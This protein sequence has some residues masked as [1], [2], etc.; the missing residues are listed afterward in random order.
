MKRRILRLTL[1]TCFILAVTAL[2]TVS[3][4]AE[5][6]R[7]GDLTY[8]VSN[9]EITIT[10]CESSVTS[11]TIPSKIN[12][13]PVASIGYKA[14]SWCTSLTSISIPDSV[15]SIGS[16]AFSWCT[17]LT[18][19]S[20]PDSVTSIGNYAFSGCTRLTSISIPDSVTSIGV[21]AFWYCTSLTSISIPDSV[22]SIGDSAFQEC[23][24]LTSVN[25]P[26]SVTSIGEGAFY[27]CSSLKN[28]YYCGTA[29]EW[30]SISIGLDNTPLTNATL[31]YH[32]YT[33]T[34][35]EPTCTEDGSATGVCELCGEV[36]D[37][38]LPALGHRV[39]CEALVHAIKTENDAAYPFSLSDG[40]Y[41]STNKADSSKSTFTITALY[42]CTLK[43]E[44]SVSSESNY[45]KL[46]ISKNGTALY[47]KS[48]VVSWTAVEIELK[49]GDKLTIS[50]SKDGS[51][52]KNADTGY[53][54]FS[55][56]QVL[57][58]VDIPADEL[59]PT[60]AES[61]VCSYCQELIK[62]ALGH[63]YS[64]WEVSDIPDEYGYCIKSR[65]CSACG[66]EEHDTVL[67]ASGDVDGDGTL[68]NAD[69]ALAIRALSGWDIDGD[70]ALI[71]INYDGKYNNRDII[72]FIRKLAGFDL[73]Y[74][75]DPSNLESR[76]YS[77]CKYSVPSST[78]E[79][80]CIS[81]DLD[82]RITL[83]RGYL[84]CEIVYGE[85][86]CPSEEHFDYNG[87]SYHN[88]KGGADEWTNVE[89]SDKYIT[90]SIG[91][92]VLKLELLSNDT[93]RVVE[94]VNSSEISAGDIFR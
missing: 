56:D 58:S 10:D 30:S 89:I 11:V 38:T 46:I 60:C 40:V 19:V 33:W 6:Y 69:V 24:S 15:T 65:V 67:F 41:S 5:T 62:A 83:Y 68:T 79:V 45:D 61:V 49:A 12:G 92:E 44:Y 21:A 37:I 57:G 36:T 28:V 22:T 87:M 71:D 66:N 13:Y 26:N 48:G 2:F 16:Y 50:Y 54:K 90:I 75:I 35:V 84:T 77:F 73:V 29:E 32:K 88:V 25:I 80:S 55:C 9:G 3:A 8:T 72:A 1:V 20:I 23:T 4:S 63:S 14:F 64:S 86:E 74:R 91:D 53:F 52:S 78:D 93:L 82:R 81:L 39:I 51:E 27:V 76:T 94:A 43:L 18:S 70:I 7:D 31:E 59:E 34:V 47:T 17:S 42:E 85:D